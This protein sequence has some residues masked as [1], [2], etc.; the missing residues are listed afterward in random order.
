MEKRK[1]GKK[2]RANI[3]GHLMYSRNNARNFKKQSKTFFVLSSQL[4]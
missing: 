4:P 1:G 2:E 3:Y